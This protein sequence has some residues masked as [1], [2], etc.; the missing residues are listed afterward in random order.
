MIKDQNDLREAVDRVRRY[1]RYKDETEIY[2][3]ERNE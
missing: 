1:L 2:D 3:K